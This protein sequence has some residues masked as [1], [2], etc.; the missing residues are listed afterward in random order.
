MDMTPR[1]A[2]A[3]TMNGVDAELSKDMAVAAERSQYPCN[4]GANN[5]RR[6]PTVVEKATAES[7]L[8]RRGSLLTDGHQR[9]VLG[10]PTEAANGCSQSIHAIS[11]M[12]L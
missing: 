6:T 10:T 1:K 9:N 12:H 7:T 4:N 8:L 5:R 3:E 2:R 11:S